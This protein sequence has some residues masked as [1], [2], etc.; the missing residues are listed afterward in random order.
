MNVGGDYYDFIRL[1]DHQLA[2][3]LGD[4]SGNGLAASLVMANLQA[5]IRSQALSGSDPAHCLE[6]ANK[7]L[8]DS[9]DARTFVS[10]FYGI[11]DTR[12]NSLFYAN[13]GQDMPIL[14]SEG[15]PPRLLSSRGIALGLTGDATYDAQI[16]SIRPGDF[17]VVYTDGIL[18]TMNAGNEEFGDERIRDLVLGNKSETARAIV[19]KLFEAVHEHAAQMTQQDDMTALIVKRT[20]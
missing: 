17:L 4:V 16:V 8:Y 6:R 1:D 15:N 5:T 3:G 12:N 18:E 10:L 13:A 9:T 20:R 19:D 14:F 7:L 11:L 2:I